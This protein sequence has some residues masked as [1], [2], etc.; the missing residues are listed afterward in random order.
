MKFCKKVYSNDPIKVNDRQFHYLI[1]EAIAYCLEHIESGKY[2]KF[3]YNIKDDP[4][5]E[6]YMPNCSL[7]VIDV[8]QIP[9]YT[10]VYKAPEDLHLVNETSFWKKLKNAIA[11]MK[12]KSGIFEYKRQEE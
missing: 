9:M 11:Y 2:Y 8:E 1:S 7:I 4:D 12:C 6:K 5:S 3:S 10:S